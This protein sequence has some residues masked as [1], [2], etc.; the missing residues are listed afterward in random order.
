MRAGRIDERRLVFRIDTLCLCHPS[1]DTSRSSIRAITQACGLQRV[2]R[3]WLEPQIVVNLPSPLYLD[4]G[5]I[6]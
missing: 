2:S 1:D 5:H 6:R 3:L 4:A